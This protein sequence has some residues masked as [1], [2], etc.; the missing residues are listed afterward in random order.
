MCIG[1][2]AWTISNSEI[3]KAAQHYPNPVASNAQG[4]V[5]QTEPH[6]DY[7]SSGHSNGIG[8]GASN[9]MTG[10][11]TDEMTGNDAEENMTELNFPQIRGVTDSYL[12]PDR[13]FDPD[14]LQD[15]LI[16]A[17]GSVGIVLRAIGDGQT[18]LVG[19]DD[20][21]I[22]L[23]YDDGICKRDTG[24]L[25]TS[26]SDE[27]ILISSDPERT[28]V[29]IYLRDEIEDTGSKR[30]DLPEM[31][32]DSADGAKAV[33]VVAEGEFEDVIDIKSEIY[34]SEIY[35]PGD[36]VTLE[37]GDTEPA[38][39]AEAA[40]TDPDEAAEI[41]ESVSRPIAVMYE[42][43]EPGNQIN[44]RYD[45]TIC[46][47]DGD[48][49]TKSGTMARASFSTSSKPAD[50]GWSEIKI[51][52][53]DR[54]VVGIQTIIYAYPSNPD[55]TIVIAEGEIEEQNGGSGDFHRGRQIYRTDV[56]EAGERVSFEIG[57]TQ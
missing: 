18:G 34:R 46:Y 37:I 11:S 50:L 51:S 39:G 57:D 23:C 15:Q 32:R 2:S 28:V 6:N 35:E 17:K 40:A 3:A 10:L 54:H 12:V 53:A 9:G 31:L 55:M 56:V 24:F 48:C 21:K 5:E 41:L 30:D 25:G 8:E 36:E 42:P 38:G 20:N 16:N 26:T 47:D 27:T 29:G 33:I 7:E 14:E 49:E 19:R 43:E 45:T 44:F 52:D 4:Q 13:E 1:V 22:T